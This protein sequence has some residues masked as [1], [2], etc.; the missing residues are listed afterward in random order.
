MACIVTPDTLL[1]WYRNLV[2]KKY[3]GSAARRPG[4]A[5]TKTN[6]QGLG[7]QLIEATIA[8]APNAGAVKCRERLGGILNFYYRDAA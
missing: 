5:P 2:A 6:H 4:R 7:N 3:D 1:R 8:S